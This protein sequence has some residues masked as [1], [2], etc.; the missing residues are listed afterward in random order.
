MA[1]C[2]NKKGDVRETIEYRS[3]VDQVYDI[4]SRID[5]LT[6]A[7]ILRDIQLKPTS[8]DALEDRIK[9]ILK[10]RSS[11]RRIFQD[12]LFGEPAWDMLLELYAVGLGG[13]TVS[14][15]SLCIASG[16]PCTTALRWIRNLETHGWIQR[17]RDP[18]DGRRFFVSLTGKGHKAM[19]RFF[20]QSEI[21]QGV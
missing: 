5:T 11:R 14:V 21:S 20:A 19:E 7:A 18:K 2:Q 8:L 4:R 17:A 13:Q 12:E 15:S 9:R 16:V 3:F 1:Q 6:E 10:L